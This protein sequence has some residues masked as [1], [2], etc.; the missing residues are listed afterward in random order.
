MEAARRYTE[1]RLA[2]IPAPVTQQDEHLDNENH[3]PAAN[4]LVYRA[5]E[6]HLKTYIRR[7]RALR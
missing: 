5:D 6:A 7:R 3:N 4:Q 1:A 2:A